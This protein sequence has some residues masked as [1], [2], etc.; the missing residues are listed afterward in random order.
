MSQIQP[1]DENKSLCKI[2]ALGYIKHMAG[3]KAYHTEKGVDENEL[4]RSSKSN[5]ERKKSAR[6]QLA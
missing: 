5:G 1:N 6:L 4:D 3:I 2:K